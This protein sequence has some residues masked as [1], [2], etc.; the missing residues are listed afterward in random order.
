MTKLTPIIGG[1]GAVLGI[2]G[3]VSYSLAPDKLWLVTLCEGLALVC[4]IGFFVIHFETVKAFSAR[5]STSLGLNSILMIILFLGILVIINFLAARH[6][7]RW[8]FSETQRFTLAPQTYQVLRGLAREVKITVFTQGD[9]Y[10]DLLDSYRHGSHFLTVDYVD[11]DQQPAI[12][13]QYGITRMETAVLESGSRSTRV[14]VPSEAELTGALI[15]VSKDT[16]KRVVF[17]EGHGERNTNNEESNGYSLVKEALTNQGY[18]VD[19]LLLLQETRVPNKTSVLV[20]AG[21]QS[22]VTKPE[23][24][25]IADYV[26]EG[27]RLLIMLDPDTRANLD[28]LIA[29]WGVEAG[30]GIL[31]DLQDRPALGDLTSLMVR[32]FTEHEITQ[33]FNS[34]VLFPV[35]RHVMFHEETGETWNFVPLARTSARSWAETDLAGLTGRVVRFDAE[36]DVKG[37]LSVAGALTPKEAA[38]EGETRAAIVIV[39]NSAFASNGYLNFPGNT[40]FLLHTISWLAEERALISITPKE[41]AFRPFLPNPTQ[42]RLLLYV[43]VLFLPALTMLWGLAVWRQRRRL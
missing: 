11:P 10:R 32:T 39:G 31:V 15:R 33:D 14:R 22:P 8:D 40:D 38:E 9:A 20:V 6:S 5:R 23:K 7:Q 34:A 29:R 21:P 43:Q 27:G 37:P 16:K 42:D 41:P 13:R 28:D 36:E 4:L 24:E 1:L 12:A 35:S 25:R 3:L 18:E 2:A 26:A 17:L 19:T 30:Q